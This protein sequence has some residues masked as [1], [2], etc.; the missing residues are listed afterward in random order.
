[1]DVDDPQNPITASD[2]TVLTGT[3][4]SGAEVE[5]A[6]LQID[7]TSER[8]EDDGEEASSGDIS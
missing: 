3:G 4:E 5:M 8:P 1:M 2:D 7:S 6:T